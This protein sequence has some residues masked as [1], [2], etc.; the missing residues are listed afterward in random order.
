MFI[1]QKIELTHKSGDRKKFYGAVVVHPT[2]YDGC[3]ELASMQ[4]GFYVMG[5]SSMQ[6]AYHCSKEIVKSHLLE[7]GP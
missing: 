3:V 5:S 2:C 6:T 4:L 7:E 1:D